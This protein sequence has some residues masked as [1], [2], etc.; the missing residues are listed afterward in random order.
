MKGGGEKGKNQNIEDTS[1]EQKSVQ[2]T[3]KEHK[4]KYH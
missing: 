2:T 3:A 4:K 1:A